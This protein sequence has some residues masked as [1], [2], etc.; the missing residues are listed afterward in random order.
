MRAFGY[1][2]YSRVPDSSRSKLDDKGVKYAPASYTQ[3][4]ASPYWVH[5]KSAINLEIG[6]LTDDNSRELVKPPEGEK[7]VSN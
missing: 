3:A 5:W 4:K 7:I 2:V 1:V 6:A